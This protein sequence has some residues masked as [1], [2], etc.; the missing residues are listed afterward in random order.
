MP[1]AP[2]F[3]DLFKGVVCFLLLEL[4]VTTARQF[5]ELKRSGVFLAVFGLEMVAGGRLV[6][7]WVNPSRLANRYASRCAL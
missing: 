6:W 4:G 5:P 2:L 1:F 3:F 7:R